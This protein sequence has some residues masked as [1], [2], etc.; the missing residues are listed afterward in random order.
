M[1]SRRMEI[2]PSSQFGKAKPPLLAKVRLRS[3]PANRRILAVATLRLRSRMLRS[4]TV[5]TTGARCAIGPL[6][7]EAAIGTKI[8]LARLRAIRRM[9]VREAHHRDIRRMVVHKQAWDRAVPLR[10]GR[11]VKWGRVVRLRRPK[12]RPTTDPRL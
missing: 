6:T 4:P 7:V 9:A 12:M 8:L 11:R 2:L 1:M 10:V 3:V 5:L